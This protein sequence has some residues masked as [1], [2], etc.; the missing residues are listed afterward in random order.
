MA[1]IQRYTEGVMVAGTTS[2]PKLVSLLSLCLLARAMDGRANDLEHEP[3]RYSTAKPH[4]AVSRLVEQLD[5]GKEKLRYEERFGYLRSLLRELDIPVSSQTL[6]F[7]K[8]SLQ[9]H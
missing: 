4:N 5:T 8:T 2:L 1:S 3:I 7:S 9:R 6:V